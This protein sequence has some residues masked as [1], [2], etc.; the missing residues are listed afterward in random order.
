MLYGHTPRLEEAFKLLHAEI[1]RTF[2]KI[3]DMF[4]LVYHESHLFMA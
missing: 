1:E 3:K 4:T 2:S